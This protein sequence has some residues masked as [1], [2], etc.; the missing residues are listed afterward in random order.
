V[1]LRSWIAEEFTPSR[2]LPTLTA[3][4]VTGVI[5]IS[6]GLSF[7]VLIFSGSLAPSVSLAISA[8]LVGSLVLNVVIALLSS[9]PGMTAAPQDGPAAVAAL[10]AAGVAS[11]LP[12]EE[13][14]GAAVTVLA[15]LA[16]ASLLTGV[17]FWLFGRLHVGGLVRF[18]PY[19]VI[20][21]FLAGTGWLILLGAFPVMTGHAVTLKS[22]GEFF[23]ASEALR[24]APGAAFGAALFFVKRR[25]THF[26]VLPGALLGSIALF[27]AV[28]LAAGGTVSEAVSGGWLLEGIPSGILLAP[29]AI[30]DLPSVH[31]PALVPEAGSLATIIGVCLLQF[32][33]YVSALEVSLHKDLDLDREMRASGIANLLTGLAGGLPGYHW[34][35]TTVLANSM[36]AKSRLVGVF[37]ALTC[38]AAL[39]SGASFLPY[40]PKMALGGLLIFLSLSFLSEWLWIAGFRMPRTDGAIVLLI[41][42]VVGAVGF[43]EG[44]AVGLL[45]AV[46][47]FVVKYSRID[48]VRAALDGSHYRSNRDRS[49]RVARL[50]HDKGESVAVFKLRGFLFFGTANSLQQKARK[51]ALDKGKQALRFIVFDFREVTGM[52]SSAVLSFLKLKDFAE[53]HSLILV[54]TH[55]REDFANLLAKEGFAEME[56]NAIRRFPDLDRGMEWCEDRVIEDE[57]AGQTKVLAPLLDHLRDVFPEEEAVQK[58]LGYCDRKV[59]ADGEVL[60]RQGQPAGELFF[61]ESGWVSVVL[62]S[63]GGAQVRLRTLGPGTVVGETGVYTGAPRTASVVTKGPAT[64]LRLSGEGLQKMEREAPEVASGFHRFIVLHLAERLSWANRTVQAMME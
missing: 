60:I 18:L 57:G 10:L 1:S 26:L 43:L 11:R 63:P 47:L 31:W 61:V 27:Y 24:W 41:L 3:G 37:A 21:G 55:I 36:G 22:L 59:L 45:A 32:L 14:S 6:V 62:E 53:S 46:V 17:A 40:V 9:A 7:A 64:V 25:W 42:G 23:S 4:L 49:P 50:L 51:R 39:L 30:L 2:L 16:I 8:V 19:P 29:P 12:A 52:D 34:T 20:G 15:A 54:L 58:F 13:G 28:F 44:V 48:V 5:Q 56:S 38:V 33:L 35:S